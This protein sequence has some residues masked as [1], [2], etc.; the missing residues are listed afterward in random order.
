MGEMKSQPASSRYARLCVAVGL[1]V[2]IWLVPAPDGVKAE[3][4]HLLAIFIATVAG[5]MLEPLPMGAVA[6]LGVTATT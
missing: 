2:A 6:V 4:W 3:A 1:G 5:I